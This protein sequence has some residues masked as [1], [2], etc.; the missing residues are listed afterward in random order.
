MQD[1]VRKLRKFIKKDTIV[2]NC[3]GVIKPNIDENCVNS[4]LNALKI[5]SVFPCNLNNEFAKKN[6]IYQIATDCV[7]DGIR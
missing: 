5:N 3:I 4:V 7:Y 2:V 6:K 1:S